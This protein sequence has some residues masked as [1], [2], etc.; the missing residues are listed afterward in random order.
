MLIARLRVWLLSAIVLASPGVT[1]TPRYWTLTGVQ[2]EEGAVATG[3]FSYDDATSTVADWNLQVSGGAARFPAIPFK[4][5]TWVPGNAAASAERSERGPYVKFQALDV[6]PRVEA[7]LMI[8]PLAPLDGNNATVLIN[9]DFQAPG[10]DCEDQFCWTGR[11]GSLT[12]A[13]LPPP[14][15]IVR[16]DEFHHPGLRR[17]F[18]TADA[19]EKQLLD[20]GV[21]PGWERTGEGFNAYAAGSRAGGSINPVCRYYGDPLRG[22][23]SHFYSADAG[24]CASVFVKFPAEWRFESDNVFQIN[25]PDR[26]TGACPENTVPVYRLWNQQTDL[27]HRYT[28]STTMRAQML[29]AG[30]R[31]EGYGADGVVMCALQQPPR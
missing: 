2:L 26:P 8:A 15:T 3:Y 30:Y 27:S 31:A 29:A 7:R 21:H 19:T 6:T 28:T 24:E 22:L 10:E 5:Y 1:A 18:L 20:S 16:V 17:F 4:P 11:S 13:P 25:L 12:L 23:D 9:L 14:I